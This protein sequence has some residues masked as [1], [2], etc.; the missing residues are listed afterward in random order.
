[1]TQKANITFKSGATV[2]VELEEGSLKHILDALSRDDVKFFNKDISI[3]L[4]EV[5]MIERLKDTPL[6]QAEG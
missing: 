4:R 1:M 6:N 2:T 5:V 3:D